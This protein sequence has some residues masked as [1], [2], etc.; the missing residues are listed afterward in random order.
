MYTERNFKTKRAL[1]EAVAR[2][3]MISIYQPGGMFVP[4][5]ALPDYTGPAFVEGP[6]YPQAHTW[7][8][9]VHLVNGLVVKVQ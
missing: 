6:H 3:E 9:K 5:E 1:K 2:N 4:Q 8:A 7:Y